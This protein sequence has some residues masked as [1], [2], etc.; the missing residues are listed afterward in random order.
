ML[1]WSVPGREA[2]CSCDG[3]VS[4]LSR[5]GL[6]GKP[7][8][9]AM[10]WLSFARSCGLAGKPAAAAMV[11]SALARSCGPGRALLQLRW[12]GQLCSVVRPRREA[13]CSCDGLVSFARSCGPGKEACCS[14]DGL[15]SFAALAF[16]LQILEQ[17][18][19]EPSGI[20]Y[21]IVRG[22]SG[23]LLHWPFLAFVDAVKCRDFMSLLSTAVS[24]AAR[25]GSKGT[26]FARL[27]Q[28]LYA[29]ACYPRPVCERCSQGT[30]LVCLVQCL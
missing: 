10:V 1:G 30:S 13:C 3:L 6:A 9:A 8:A 20:P 22:P 28:A 15:M 25:P 11:W 17:V 24:C 4:F 7:A 12:F 19:R 23:A 5:A 26:S 27:E 18:P 16:G 21:A 29:P 2:C 14:C